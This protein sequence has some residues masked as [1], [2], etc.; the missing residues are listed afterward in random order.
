MVLNIVIIHGYTDR[1]RNNNTP[2]S[3]LNAISSYL[4]NVA[5][6]DQARR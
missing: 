2:E 1:G 4:E 6:N 5:C 3:S